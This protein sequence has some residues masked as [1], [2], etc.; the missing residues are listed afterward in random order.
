L[1]VE[2]TLQFEL[3]GGGVRVIM[4]TP[5]AIDVFPRASVTIRATPTSDDVVIRDE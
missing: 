1:L 5:S 2:S 4:T 3:Q